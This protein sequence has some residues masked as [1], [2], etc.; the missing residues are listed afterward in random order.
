MALC[1]KKFL[2]LLSPGVCAGIPTFRKYYQHLISPYKLDTVSTRRVTRTKEKPSATMAT[3]A[4]ALRLVTRLHRKLQLL[5]AVL[6]YHTIL[7]TTI[8]INKRYSER[9][10]YLKSDS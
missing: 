1:K 5:E 10:G 7:K 6:I 2:A 8:K 3:Y 4:D 9:R